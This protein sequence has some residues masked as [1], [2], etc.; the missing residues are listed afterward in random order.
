[1][2]GDDLADVAGEPV[3]GEQRVEA[4][5]HPPFGPFVG[6]SLG[7]LDPDPAERREDG[8][9]VGVDHV[10]DV[11]AVL[12]DQLI[13]PLRADP[14]QRA[15][16]APRALGPGRVER[17]RL[18]DR[19]LQAVAGV[20]LDRAPDQ[21]PLVLGEV[22]ERP[23]ERHRRPVVERRLGDREGPV[24]GGEAEELDRHLGLERIAR[25]RPGVQQRALL[26]LF[27][28][29]AHPDDG[30]RFGGAAACRR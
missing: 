20:M 30:K 15:Q 19:D 5:L 27:A 1:M 10:E 13:R 16:V 29:S 14:R 8:D 7:G 18:G 24:G 12:G 17:L 26:A 4:A 2:Q 21:R 22:A 25:A 6:R 3:R 23:G 11:L 9:R 28:E